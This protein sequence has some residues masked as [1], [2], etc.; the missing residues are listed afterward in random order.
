MKS[1]KA[2]KP[3]SKSQLLEFYER[4]LLVREAENKLSSL[5]ADGEVPGFIHLSVGQEAVCVG[6]TSALEK[7]DTLASNH[8]GHGHA[9]SKGVELE[10]FFLEVMGKEEGI[11]GG[12]GGSM[13]VADM[14]VGMLGANGIVGAGIPLAIGSALAHQVKKNDA[15]AVV[16]FGDG[17]LAE[18]VLHESFN[19]ASLWKLP[20]LF[21]CENNGWSEFSPA[22]LQFVANVKDLVKAF[23]IPSQCVD[24]N[25][26]MDVH[27]AADELA[28]AARR[29]EGPQ[30]LECIT[31]RVRG[32]FEGDPQK[33][34]TEEELTSISEHDPITKFEKLIATK[35]I[36]K[37]E[38]QAVREKVD[39]K[40]SNA[41]DAGRGGSDPDFER[42]RTDVYTAVEG[43]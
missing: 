30:L 34:R 20:V 6:I 3:A 4:M 28:N 7:Q 36:T 2:G 31:H 21:V 13:H 26:V 14:S 5:F 22:N 40:I 29:G 32:H 18:G 9:L 11:C 16:F 19:L 17:A 24:G 42:A 43:L 8:R 41:V 33:Y 12:R 27:K 15:I 1:T 10:S 38:M 23:D 39:Q 37:K 35:R 25:E